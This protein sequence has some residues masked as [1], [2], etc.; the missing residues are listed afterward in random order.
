M[1]QSFWKCGNMRTWCEQNLKC[2]NVK[3]ELHDY[4]ARVYLDWIASHE[5]FALRSAELR[6]SAS[7]FSQANFETIAG[8][9]FRREKNW[10]KQSWSFDWVD[11]LSRFRHAL[12]PD[13]AHLSR[14]GPRKRVNLLLFPSRSELELLSR[15]YT[16]KYSSVR[17]LIVQNPLI[18][19]LRRSVYL[20]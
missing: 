11:C 14:L 7:L 16:L 12:E 5:Q 15:H 4:S 2:Q 19:W 1:A 17:W 20:D 18:S 6:A 9:C 10:L 13:S 3:K 8:P